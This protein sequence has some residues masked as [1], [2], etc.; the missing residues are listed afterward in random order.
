M[1]KILLVTSE[2]QIT[3]DRCAVFLRLTQKLAS[4][5]KDI[6]KV[7]D[8]ISLVVTKAD[9]GVDPQAVRDELMAVKKDHESSKES[10]TFKD[11]NLKKL[12]ETIISP[13]SKIGI[14]YTPTEEGLLSENL[15]FRK[16][17]VNIKNAVG[18]SSY[19]YKPEINIPISDKSKVAIHRV[20]DFEKQK[21]S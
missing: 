2:N 7:A 13:K 17:I 11:P 4:M 19:I 5:F 10:S 3:S 14:F 8:G 12:F 1:V 16:S 20:Y 21:A 6:D 15:E 9:E 18:S